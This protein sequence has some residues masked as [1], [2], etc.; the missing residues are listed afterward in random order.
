MNTNV[1]RHISSILAIILCMVGLSSCVDEFDHGVGRIGEGCVTIPVTASFDA[2]DAVVLNSRS[3]GGTSGTAIEDIHTLWLM[4]YSPEG[5]RLVQY[6]VYGEAA[7]TPSINLLD[8]KV[9]D[10][11][12]KLDDNRLPDEKPDLSDISTGKVTFRLTIPMGRYYIYAV[13]NLDVAGIAKDGSDPFATRE[14]MLGYKCTWSNADNWADKGDN[15]EMFGV[16]TVN[17]PDRNANVNQLSVITDR[18][19][20]IHSWVKRLASKVTVA[21]NGSDLYDNVQVFISS[22]QIKDIPRECTLRP[23]DALNNRPGLDDEGRELNGRDEKVRD[24]VLFAQGQTVIVQ[25]LPDDVSGIR[26]ADY[27]HVCNGSHPYLG[28]GKEEETNGNDPAIIDRYHAHDYEHSLFFYENCQG[29]GKSKKQDAIN[30]DTKEEIPDYK[31]DF[32]NPDASVEGSGWK[33][34][35]PFGTYVEVRGYYRCTSNS[36]YATA[37]DIVYRFMLGQDTDK[38]YN[39]LRNTHYK[40][41]LCFKGYG[42]DADWHIEYNEPAGIQVTTPQYISYPYNKSMNLTVKI[43]GILNDNYKLRAEIVEGSGETY[44]RP[45]GDGSKDFPLPDKDKDP[46]TPAN[47]AYWQEDV[48]VDG[49]WNSFLSMRRTNALEVTGS[50]PSDNKKFYEEHKRGWR[51]YD[52]KDGTHYDDDDG[53]YRVSVSKRNEVG[54]AVERIFAIP[55]YT[56]AKNLITGTGYTGNNPYTAYPRKERIKFTVVDASGVPVSGIDPVYVDVIQVR[57]IVNPKGV[58]RRKGSRE[59]FNVT[60]M[61]LYTDNDYIHLNPNAAFEEFNSDGSWSAEV[62]AGGDN[63]IS[64]SST[65]KG[66]GDAVAQTNVRRIEGASEHP[67]DF[68]INFNGSEG[69]AIVRVRYH[70]YTCEHDIFCRNGYDPI[71][72]RDGGAKWYSYNVYRFEDRKAILTKSPLQE[73]SFFRGQNYTAILASNNDREGYKPFQR[74][75]SSGL[76]VI[77]PDAKIS[78][79]EEEIRSSANWSDLRWHPTDNRPDVSWKISNEDMHIAQIA[80]YYAIASSELQ[81]DIKNAY[82]V[83][84]ADGA[85]GTA[86]TVKDAYGYDYVDGRDSEKGM[87]GVIVY[88]AKNSRQ[89]FFPIGKHG[90]GRRKSG[91]ITNNNDSPGTLR[92][93]GRTEY[94]GFINSAQAALLKD[95]PL[96]YDLYRRYGAVYWCRDYVFDIKGDYNKS[97]AFDLNYF[98]MGFQGYGNDAM[99]QS[100]YGS[101]IVEPQG[102]F[103]RT[104]V[105]ADVDVV[106]PE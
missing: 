25:D 26:P 27:L 65:P 67:I 101:G 74:T 49:P 20:A 58:W 3:T 33:D 105:G 17:D 69:C 68:T 66:S 9:S 21:F 95:R 5:D 38:D 98:T 12:H 47:F 59:P 15:D 8:I 16:F 42:N 24:K 71:A 44:W 28:K 94:Y 64:L 70:N 77:K 52:V 13:A 88:N 14:G 55:L 82:G 63:I 39:A 31:V 100:S 93:A 50:S 34:E 41:T 90:L 83:L 76:W 96:F 104:V 91:Y 103:V 102:C 6:P 80:D 54:V 89:I 79:N 57:R 11:A 92:Y 22:I 75:A 4:V 72:I 19:S 85:K 99:P 84:Y 37:G 2:P 53:N 30:N 87:R 36:A 81:S 106:V 97:S 29:T 60:L 61:R 62:V 43:S 78:D 40:L 48:N 18:T 7:G 46:I 73:G 10:V 23:G 1:M 45:W 86:I 35:K 51:T 56:R 32:P